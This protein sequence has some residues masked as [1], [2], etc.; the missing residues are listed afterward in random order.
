ME[1]LVIWLETLPEYVKMLPIAAVL[2][3]GFGVIASEIIIMI[4]DMNKDS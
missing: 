4:E 3:I 1:N 2:V